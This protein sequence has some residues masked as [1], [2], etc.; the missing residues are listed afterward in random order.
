MGAWEH[1]SMEGWKMEDGRWKMQDAR[2]KDERWEPDEHDEHDEH[3][4]SK[5]QGT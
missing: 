4:A 3:R 2:C 1:G 5:K